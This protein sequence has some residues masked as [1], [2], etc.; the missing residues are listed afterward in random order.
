[1][2]QRDLVFLLLSAAIIT[3]I[4]YSISYQGLLYRY[5]VTGG[6]EVVLRAPS[7]LGTLAATVFGFSVMLFADLHRV[8]LWRWVYGALIA[9]GLAGSVWAA[10][11]EYR[12]SAQALVG[13]IFLWGL[14]W[15]ISMAD[16]WR[17]GHANARIFL[18]S[19]AVYC[20]CL[21]LRLAF[22]NGLLPGRW[23]GGPEVAW[24]L[25]SVS[26]MLAVLV[27]GR[28]RQHRQE[29]LAVKPSSRRRVNAST[30]AWITPS[31][32]ARRPCRKH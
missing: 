15:P 18:L 24:D 17:R 27:H 14:V 5:V 31:G 10:F 8:R 23:E 13:L 25:L 9:V 2:A 1:M 11:G 7:V 4:L 3:E 12:A 21:F 20:A 16:G 26:L 32:N 30:S 28:T 19:F 29:K 22:I 6:G